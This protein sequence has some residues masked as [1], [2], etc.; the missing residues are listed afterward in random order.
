MSRLYRV[1]HAR[2]TT[3]C[4]HLSLEKT[5]LRS[6]F[7]TSFKNIYPVQILRWNTKSEA[8]WLNPRKWLYEFETG[9]CQSWKVEKIYPLTMMFFWVENNSGRMWYS[10]QNAQLYGSNAP[11]INWCK[12]SAQQALSPPNAIP[13]PSF[14]RSSEITF[15][16]LSSFIHKETFFVVSGFFIWD[17]SLN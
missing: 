10:Q 5:V 14:T 4:V 6:L 12:F 7:T 2:W 3:S 17:F 15:I 13:R 16:T 9:K 11:Y 8:M 1:I